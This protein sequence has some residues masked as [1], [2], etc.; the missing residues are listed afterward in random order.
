MMFDP[1]M[2]NMCARLKMA[3][4]GEG[5][6][7]VPGNVR[8]KFGFRFFHPVNKNKPVVPLDLHSIVN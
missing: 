8:P 5:S 4:A 2:V 1:R 7:D 6:N 3:R